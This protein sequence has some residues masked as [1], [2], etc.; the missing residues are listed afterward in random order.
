MLKKGVAARALVADGLHAAALG[1]GDDGPPQPLSTPLRIRSETNARGI[2]ASD[3]PAPR[4][5]CGSH[6]RDGYRF[7]ITPM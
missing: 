2:S 4:S 7:L 3:A 6:L 5:A 1:D